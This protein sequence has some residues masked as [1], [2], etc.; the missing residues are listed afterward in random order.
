MLFPE[1]VAE[2]KAVAEKMGILVAHDSSH[3]TGLIAGGVYPNPLDQGADIMF[4]STHKSFPGPQGGFIATRDFNI[5]ERVGNVLASLVTSHH[6]NRL[7][8]LAV[9]MLE[10]KEFG[11]AYGEQ[12]IRNSK[13]L[14]RPWKKPA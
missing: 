6:L 10:M 5:Y 13:T 11:K 1:P 7:P 9:G 14:A 8:A 3:V 12:I 4:G 2:I